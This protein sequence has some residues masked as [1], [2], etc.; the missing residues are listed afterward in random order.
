MVANFWLRPGNAHTSNNFKAFLEETLSFFENKKIGLLRLDRGFYNQ[1]IFNYLE[2]E[3]T[4]I[5]YITAVPM[6]VS[7]QRKTLT[8]R[9]WMSIEE[10]I[11]IAE[12]EYKAQDWEKSR[13][14]I[15]VRQKVSKRPN[16]VGKQLS[17]FED[18][19][20]QNDY[21]YTCYVTTLK[22]SYADIWRLYRGRASITWQALFVHL[23]QLLK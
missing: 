18:D 2:N 12:F 16:A 15:T 10:D 20:F 9:N 17:L 5:D 1:D 3:D 13:R 14:M 22:L 21:R 6:Y 7:I 11:E 23:A 4:A 19:Y 8:T